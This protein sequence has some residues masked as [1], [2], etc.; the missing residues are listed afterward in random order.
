MTICYFGIYNPEY[1]RNRILIKGLKQ[2]GVKVIECNS[3]LRGVRKYFDLIKKH[4]QLRHKYDVMIVGFPGYQAMI[5][6]R[7]LTRRPI[8][9]DAFTSIYDA[10]VLDRKTIRRTSF[11][12]KYFWF[13]DWLSCRLA[14]IV[15]L[16]TN[17]HIKFF[18]N[19]FKLKRNK[20]KKILIGAS[21]DIFFPFKKQQVNKNFTVVFFGSFISVQGVEYVIQAAKIL[22]DY[23]INFKI[24]GS[25]ILKEKMI[26]LAQELKLSNL[27][28]L[29]FLPQD[30]FLDEINKADVCL[31]IFGNTN[32]AQRVIANKIF[33]GAAMKK[34]II[35]ADTPGIRELFSEN[36]LCLVKAAN[37][38]SLAKGI[39]RLK[40][41][42][43]MREYLANNCYN[44][45]I[46][47]ATPKIL[48]KQLKQI[49]EEVI[50]KKI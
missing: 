41:N 47:K 24:I 15:L 23:N 42:S 27:Q 28:F 3:R 49:I 44:K 48:G 17:E 40:D 14:D 4:W 21:T 26:K 46:T 43:K 1:S 45:I 35:T 32:R 6:A 11:R 19:F 50:T 39:L 18:V 31:G 30:Q 37:P 34:A 20:F 38:Q 7:F 12:A 8:I 25:G 13:L 9:F 10:V 16:D 36:D 22:E 2:N 33:E 29:G 5:L